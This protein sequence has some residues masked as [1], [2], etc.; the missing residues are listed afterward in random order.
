MNSSTHTNVYYKLK[1]SILAFLL[2]GSW[3]FYVNLQVSLQDGIISGLAQG[4]LSFVFTWG[5]IHVITFF[6]NLF[7]DP[8]SRILLPVI[9][10]ICLSCSSLI[11]V[12]YLIGTPNIF[13]TIFPTT[14]VAFLFS[15]Y[16]TFTLN[17]IKGEATA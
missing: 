3:A 10:T 2:W 11:L 5:L 1:S 15:L 12:H 7:Y 8:L 14:I 4:V 13:K 16:T 17:R 6:F 9:F